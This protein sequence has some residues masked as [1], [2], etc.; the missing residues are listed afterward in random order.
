MMGGARGSRPAGGHPAGRQ[1]GVGAK[2]EDVDHEGIEAAGAFC[3]SHV[4]QIA[5][6]FISTLACRGDRLAGVAGLVQS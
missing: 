5:V 2:A 6:G 3:G 4:D 1:S